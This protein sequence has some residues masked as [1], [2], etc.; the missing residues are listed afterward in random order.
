MA[1]SGV[2]RAEV[3]LSVTFIVL[4]GAAVALGVLAYL[5]AGDR[6]PL[7]AGRLR[8]LK[9]VFTESDGI[10]LIALGASTLSGS[11]VYL[12]V[13]VR[14]K[15]P[16]PSASEKTSS[17]E[18][19]SAPEKPLSVQPTEEELKA[20]HKKRTEQDAEGHSPLC[21]ATTAK[22]ESRMRELFALFAPL[23]QGD[24]GS[25]RA[26]F[27]QEYERRQGLIKELREGK[28]K[29]ESIPNCALFG[30]AMSALAQVGNVEW[31]KKCAQFIPRG[32]LLATIGSADAK[33]VEVYK[34]ALPELHQEIEAAIRR[35]QNQGRDDGT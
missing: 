3:G 10:V 17:P 22:D 24:E 26:Q 14:R 25:Y 2:S 35:N 15:A 7:N 12:M 34:R 33:S 20:L 5:A 4:G 6:L 23:V 21:Q 19:P 9:A 8:E 18:K 1:V 13:A 29:P 16:T 28:L 32:G 30:E 27:Q 11:L 31:V